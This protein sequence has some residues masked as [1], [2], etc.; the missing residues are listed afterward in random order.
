MRRTI[1]NCWKSLRPN[2]A[3]CGRVAPKS[4]VTTVVTPRKWPGRT[5]PSSR[6]ASAPGSTWV[7]KPTGYIAAAVGA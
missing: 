3:T 7:W 4:L 6:S 1:A 5:G 2:T